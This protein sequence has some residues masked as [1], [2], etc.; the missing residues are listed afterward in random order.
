[1]KVF[2]VGGYSAG[3]KAELRRLRER[4]KTQTY[5]G[6]ERA[7]LGSWLESK[8]RAESAQLRKWVA[9]K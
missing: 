2:M 3:T 9:V 1:M 8:P 6:K 4:E 5:N 7:K